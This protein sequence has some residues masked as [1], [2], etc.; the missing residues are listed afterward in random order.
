MSFY[1][2]DLYTSLLILYS[3]FMCVLVFFDKERITLLMQYFI[4]QKYAIKYLPK[5]IVTGV[6]IFVVSVSL[7]HYIIDFYSLIQNR[8]NQGLS[9]LGNSMGDIP[10]FIEVAQALE[11]CKKTTLQK[12]TLPTNTLNKI[13]LQK[14]TLKIQILIMSWPTQMIL[15]HF[16]I[17]VSV[18]QADYQLLQQ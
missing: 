12:I 11:I 10:Y 7:F 3:F 14:N 1:F 2:S 13:T 15:G 8:D 17:P 4:N 18:V 5:H 16:L 9:L 6:F